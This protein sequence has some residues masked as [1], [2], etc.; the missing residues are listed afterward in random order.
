MTSI[1]E[2]NDEL[3]NYLI[4]GNTYYIINDEYKID[5]FNLKSR[6]LLENTVSKYYKRVKLYTYSTKYPNCIL[7]IFIEEDNDDDED[8][9]FE[10]YFNNIEE[11]KIFV[12]AETDLIRISENKI[13]TCDKLYRQID[14]DLHKE[15]T[16]A[17][18]K[19]EKGLLTR[20]DLRI[21]IDNTYKNYNLLFD[22][23]VNTYIQKDEINYPGTKVSDKD[24][25][26]KFNKFYYYEH[27]KYDYECIKFYDIIKHKIN[28]KNQDI[29]YY[30]L[31]YNI[32]LDKNSEALKDTFC[33]F[34]IQENQIKLLSTI[35]NEEEEEP[36]P[37]P[38]I[39]EINGC[40]YKLIK[41]E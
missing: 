6:F 8:K 23:L 34:S 11:V 26:I 21:V 13:I 7:A 33:T 22:H 15:L 31:Y 29:N 14:S 24:F 16:I 39:I 18:N 37:K 5:V 10:L 35:I 41:I 40:R 19:Y 2:N 30:V 25:S 36:E 1:K 27:P 32:Y 38:D 17:D 12:I 9:W 28:V 3:Q 4:E 20:S